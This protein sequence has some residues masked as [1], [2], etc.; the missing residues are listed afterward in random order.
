MLFKGQ[1]I[2]LSLDTDAIITGYTGS[3]LYKKPNDATGSWSGTIVNDTVS[4]TIQTGDIDVAGVW[5]LQ[6]KAVSG[7]IVKFGKITVIE[8]RSH[9]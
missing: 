5:E 4:Y 7:T 3:I 9:L 8:F 2:I 1:T 6:A